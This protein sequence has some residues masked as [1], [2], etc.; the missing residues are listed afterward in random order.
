MFDPTSH[1]LHRPTT[2][3]R[4]KFCPVVFGTELQQRYYRQEDKQHVFGSEWDITGGSRR[5]KKIFLS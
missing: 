5:T 3:G 4:D 2:S 1:R